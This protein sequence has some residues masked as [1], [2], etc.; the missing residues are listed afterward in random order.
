MAENNNSNILILTV[1]LEDAEAVLDLQREIVEE[2]DF[3]ISVPEEFHKTI[4]QQREAIEQM[5]A[6]DRAIMLVAEIDGS[7]VS[8][9]SFSSPNRLG[10]GASTD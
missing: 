2:G 10:Q 5:I 9:I 3:F 1:R 8:S 6:N 7:V 4:E